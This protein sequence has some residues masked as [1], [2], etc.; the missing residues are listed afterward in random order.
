LAKLKKV[1]AIIKG[2]LT[3]KKYLMKYLNTK[4]VDNRSFNYNN[5]L[6]IRSINLGSDIINY[7]GLSN[8]ANSDRNY[9]NYQRSINF[10]AYKQNSLECQ[11]KPKIM[12]N[13]VR[14][15]K[16]LLFFYLYSLNQK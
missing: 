15:I 1:Q 2:R 9:N 13:I 12:Q 8:G 11:E 3:R 7:G 14:K 6:E 4:E 5:N 10:P 16:I